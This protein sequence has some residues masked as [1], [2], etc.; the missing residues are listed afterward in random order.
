MPL[1]KFS[2]SKYMSP[3][4]CTTMYYI[5]V[6]QFLEKSEILYGLAV[7]AC[8]KMILQAGPLWKVLK[9]VYSIQRSRLIK[10]HKNIM[11]NNAMEWWNKCSSRFTKI[12]YITWK[13]WC[14]KHIFK[15]LEYLCQIRCVAME[16]YC[17]GNML[18]WRYIC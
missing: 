3:S 9:L 5:C 8:T 10:D 15:F 11:I 16:I 18:L 12:C 17:H 1:A 4:I 14:L 7:I 13:K 2:V 6:A